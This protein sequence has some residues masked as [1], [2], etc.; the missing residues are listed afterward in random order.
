[1]NWGRNWAA[2]I[3]TSRFC[4]RLGLLGFSVLQDEGENLAL[5]SHWEL[6]MSCSGL[7]QN[8]SAA[9]PW[10]CSLAQTPTHSCGTEPLTQGYLQGR[11]PSPVSS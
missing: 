7:S 9:L 4:C 5:L 6:G 10:D 1:M 11:V 2:Q 8:P 3:D